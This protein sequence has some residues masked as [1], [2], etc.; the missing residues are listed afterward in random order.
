ML[1]FF[2]NMRSEHR[3]AQRQMLI[4]V[5]LLVCLLVKNTNKGTEGTDTGEHQNTNKGMAAY[6]IQN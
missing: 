3:A 6:K 4:M 5:N 1:V 2:T